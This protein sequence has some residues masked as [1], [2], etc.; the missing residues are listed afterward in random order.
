ME[1]GRC[2]PTPRFVCL[3]PSHSAHPAIP[4]SRFGF[5]PG[6]ALAIVDA[7]ELVARCAVTTTL[8]GAM[9]GLTCLFTNMVRPCHALSTP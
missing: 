9:G 8:A 7:S 1:D 3:L 4:P 5:N 6:S 2:P